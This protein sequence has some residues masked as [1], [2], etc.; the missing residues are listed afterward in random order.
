MLGSSEK[1][2]KMIADGP[3]RAHGFLK[4]KQKSRA[5]SGL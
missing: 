2:E 5:G 1:S 4:G 3:R